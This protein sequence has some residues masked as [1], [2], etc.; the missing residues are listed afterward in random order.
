MVVYINVIFQ[1]LIMIGG[2]IHDVRVFI[3]NINDKEASEIK[4]S[5][6]NIYK[7]PRLA[8]LATETNKVEKNWLKSNKE[9]DLSPVVSVN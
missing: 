6:E 9:K 3:Y 2:N 8:N 7:D 5:L 1:G 4:N